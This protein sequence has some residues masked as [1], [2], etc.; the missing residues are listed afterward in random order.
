MAENDFVKKWNC[1]PAAP[2]C[3]GN[4]KRVSVMGQRVNRQRGAIL[5]EAVIGIMLVAIIGAG[6]AQVL[7]T[8]LKTQR[9]ATTQ[10]LAI[11]QLREHLQTSTAPPVKIGEEAL[12]LSNETGEIVPLD[13]KVAN[14]EATKR[15]VSKAISRQLS[16]DNQ[17]LFGGTVSI[18]LKDK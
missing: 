13:I 18:S 4:V 16:V 5:L 7:A 2:A 6:L 17:D 11:I 9:Y 1:F 8:T 12:T 3:F 10:N 14:V 15:T